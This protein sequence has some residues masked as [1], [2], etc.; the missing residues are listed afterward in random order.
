MPAKPMSTSSTDTAARPHRRPVHD[1]YFADPFV[2]KHD[3]QYYAIG[4]GAPEAVGQ[5]R[6]QTHVFPLLRSRDL[7]EWQPAGHAL[8]RLSDNFGD[9]YWA[10]EIAWQ[11]GTFF[12]YY[13]VGFADKQHQLRVAV[14]RSPL[15]PYQDVGTPLTDRA[16]CP[17]A[18]DPH[19]FRDDDGR[20]YLFYARD[21]LD[22]DPGSAR[23]RRRAGTAIVARRLQSMTAFEPDPETVVLRARHDWQRFARERPM[24]GRTFDW[25]TLEGPCVRKYQGRYFCLYSGGRWEDQSY[26]VDHG[27]ASRVL[28]PYSDA[29][30]ENGPRVLRSEPPLLLGPGHNSMVRGPDDEASFIAYHAWDAGMKTRRMFIDRIEWTPD[31][32]RRAS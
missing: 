3:G 22:F 18:I 24:Y 10:P 6:T 5:A 16:E 20:W 19:P 26:G 15:G 17:F 28:G 29:G 31:G 27:V 7:V 12:L 14:G 8:P 30:S 13:S 32:P 2:W 9:S 23:D 4:T 1:G 25:H 11:D 21:F